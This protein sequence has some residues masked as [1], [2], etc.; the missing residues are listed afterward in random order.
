ME[1]IDFIVDFVVKN[2]NKY[3][4]IIII[5]CIYNNYIVIQGVKLFRL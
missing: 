5:I 1:D 2:S 3:T 4:I